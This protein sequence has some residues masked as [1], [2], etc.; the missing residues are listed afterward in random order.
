MQPSPLPRRPVALLA[1]LGRRR[2]RPGQCDEVLPQRATPR[3]RRRDELQT[4]CFGP[5]SPNVSA[6]VSSPKMPSAS[7]L[8]GSNL[9]VVRRALRERRLQR[10]VESGHVVARHGQRRRVGPQQACREGRLGDREVVGRHCRCV[11]ARRSAMWEVEVAGR[12][13]LKVCGT[14]PVFPSEERPPRRLCCLHLLSSPPP[15]HLSGECVFLERHMLL[16]FADLTS[17][18]QK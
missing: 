7:G 16:P 15:H 10:L 9:N 11:R 17:T 14:L 1:S 3:C 4:P 2:L 6:L 13:M 5:L 8:L 18:L 12:G